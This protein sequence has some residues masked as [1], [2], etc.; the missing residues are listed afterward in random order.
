MNPQDERVPELL[1]EKFIE[2][3]ELREKQAMILP[4]GAKLILLGYNREGWGTFRYNDRQVAFDFMASKWDEYLKPQNWWE[5][6]LGLALEYISLGETVSFADVEQ[7][8]KNIKA[9][10]L[11]W[12]PSK[13]DAEVPVTE[14]RFLM[15]PWRR[16]QFSNP[17]LEIEVDQ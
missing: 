17:F 3:G 15:T 8:A 14:V 9:V 13:R 6:W 10:L 11:A 12:P 16:W 7:F 1:T 5:V 2:R 4:N